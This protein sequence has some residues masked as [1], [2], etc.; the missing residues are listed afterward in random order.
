MKNTTLSLLFFSFFTVVFA[1]NHPTEKEPLC[2]VKQQINDTIIIYAEV[3]SANNYAQL[4]TFI[5]AL[6]ADT[7]NFVSV[8]YN[9][10]TS[11]FTVE[12]TDQITK[13]SVMHIFKEEY[14]QIK[15]RN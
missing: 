1:T 6:E 9:F 10:E 14:G 13:L 11:E 4:H 3:T 15:V 5:S 2:W 7:T 12:F 8:V